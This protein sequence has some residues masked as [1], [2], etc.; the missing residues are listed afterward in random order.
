M[1]PKLK[2]EERFIE[3]IKEKKFNSLEMQGFNVRPDLALMAGAAIGYAIG[4]EDG[5]KAVNDLLESL[6]RIGNTP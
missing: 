3:A 1:T 6:N 5:K 4:I 2:L